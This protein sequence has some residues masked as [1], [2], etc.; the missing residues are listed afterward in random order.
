MSQIDEK[1]NSLNK[2]AIIVVALPIAIVAIFLTLFFTIFNGDETEENQVKEI[3]SEVKVSSSDQ[4]A[5]EGLAE[6]LINQAGT[7]GVKQETITPNN[8]DEMA[9]LLETNVEVAEYYFTPRAVSYNNIDSLIFEGSPIDYSVTEVNQWSNDFETNFRNSFK[10][11]SVDAVAD[12][13]SAFV[14][15][16]GEQVEVVNVRVSFN[17]NETMYVENG[18]EYGALRTYSVRSKDFNNNSATLMFAKDVDGDWKL[19]DIRNLS[20]K[21]LLSTWNDPKSDSFSET[22]FN[23]PEIDKITPPDQN[24]EENPT[25]E[26]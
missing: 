26:E 9:T 19:Y 3:K 21:F 8:I 2:R 23:F 12:D 5:L 4:I 20:N 7:F 1:D 13:K 11:K 25:D 16:N 15:V 18:S 14:T 10:I 17:S 6:Q 24:I 22:Q